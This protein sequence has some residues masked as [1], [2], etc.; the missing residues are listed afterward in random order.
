[1]SGT[2]CTYWAIP[3]ALLGYIAL[4]VVAYKLGEWSATDPYF[5]AVVSW[6]LGRGKK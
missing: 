4:M 5:R 2:V 3:L 6:I 1:M